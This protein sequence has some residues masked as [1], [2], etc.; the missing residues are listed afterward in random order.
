[1]ERSLLI[2]TPRL[3]RRVRA[4][5]MVPACGP[6]LLDFLRMNAVETDRAGRIARAR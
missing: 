2:E 1:L 6:L 4:A 3:S 5:G